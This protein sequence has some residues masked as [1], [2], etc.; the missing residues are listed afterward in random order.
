MLPVAAVFSMATGVGST[1]WPAGA[2]TG[3]AV[4][5]SETAGYAEGTVAGVSPDEELETAPRMGNGTPVE[6]AP[7][8]DAASSVD[9]SVLVVVGAGVSAADAGGIAEEV[10]GAVLGS[11]EEG[12]VLTNGAGGAV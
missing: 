9:G 7:G 12:A 5:P 10:A 11:V 3:M 1:T 2:A 8:A 6:A 4:V